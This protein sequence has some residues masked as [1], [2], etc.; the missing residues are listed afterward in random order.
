MKG[1]FLMCV[2]LVLVLPALAPSARAATICAVDR[3]GN[4]DAADE[5]ELA[6]CT[7]AGDGSAL[8]PID[9]TPCAQDG[10][11]AYSCPLGGQYSCV[12]SSPGSVPSCSPHACVNTG[13]NP[14]ETVEPV[15][16]PGPLADGTVDDAGTCMGSVE[17][18]AGRAMRCRPPGASVTFQNCC[19]DRDRIIKDGM[20]GSIGSIGTKIA[21]AKGVFTGMKAA[22][23]AFRAGATAGQA[24][25]AGANAIIIGIDPTSIAISL[26]INYMMEVLLAGCDAQDMETG[27]LKGSG[28]CH[29]TGSYCASSVLGIC[30]Q[31]ARGHCCFNTKLGRILQEQ[32]RPQLS[33][34]SQIGWGTAHEPYCRGFTAEEFQALDFSRMDLSEYYSE[35]EARAQT[36]IEIDMKD[37]VDAYLETVKP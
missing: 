13:T 12:I 20:G 34:F 17:I 1:A 35:I 23:T 15:D 2:A 22:Y 24:A 27:M 33:S 21:V 31:K 14:V 10:G 18:F 28:M 36:E 4:G 19:R 6:S 37:R 16:D 29:E 8:C 9:A 32:G 11:G 25:S 7:V 3:N 30:I 5:G 26:A